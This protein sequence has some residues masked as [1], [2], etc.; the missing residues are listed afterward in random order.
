MLTKFVNS[1]GLITRKQAAEIAAKAAADLPQW[2]LDYAAANQWNVP[3]PEKYEAQA[4]LMQKIIYLYTAVMLTANSAS[5]QDYDVYLRDEEQPNHAMDMLLK[6]PNPNQTGFEFLRDHFAYKLLT[7]GSYWWINATNET[8]EPSELWIIP[9]GN[10]YPVPDAKLGIKEYIYLP[11]DGQEIPIPTWQIIWFRGFHPSNQFAS[12]SA[13]EPLGQTMRTDIDTQNYLRTIYGPNSGR[14]PGIIAFKSPV[15]DVDWRKIKQDV[16]KS[17]EE[18]NYLLLRG[19]GDGVTWLNAA[20]TLNE[21]QV[22]QGRA[23]TKTDIVNAIAPGLIN[24]TSENATEANSKTGKQTFSEFTLYPMLVDT[25]QK[26]NKELATRYGDKVK[27]EFD[28][29][30]DIAQQAEAA[31]LAIETQRASVFTSYSAKLPVALAAKLAD[32]KLPKGITFDMLSDPQ[33]AAPPAPILPAMQS[34]APQ[35]PAPDAIAAELATWQKYAAKH[36]GTKARQ[37]EPRTI[38]PALAFG[39]QAGLS[40]A[41][42]AQ[43]L[44]GVF[45]QAAS[46]LQ[47]LRLAEKIG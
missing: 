1:L 29:P 30:R 22:Y 15:N 44:A 12:L 6:A 2:W 17:S 9:P 18:R 13:V 33:P 28:D 40:A 7:G 34:E 31:Q 42:D 5:S 32:L 8:A 36:W 27:L 23:M 38:P 47:L 24:M 25:A 35:L 46:D 37:F 19:V 3:A 16:A 10:I 11:G 21:M 26:I 43:D 4:D 20:A 39:V 14:L 41:K 45:A